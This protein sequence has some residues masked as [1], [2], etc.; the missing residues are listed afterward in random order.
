MSIPLPYSFMPPGAV[1]N[2]YSWPLFLESLLTSHPHPTLAFSPATPSSLRRG[3]WQLRSKF[4]CYMWWNFQKN[5]QN[6]SEMEF[7]PLQGREEKFLNVLRVPAD[8]FTHPHLANLL[9][10]L[11][12]PQPPPTHSFVGRNTSLHKPSVLVPHDREECVGISIN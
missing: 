1:Q 4:D 3:R 6:D 5:A 7:V 9:P 10:A 2:A 11:L 8:T 12:P